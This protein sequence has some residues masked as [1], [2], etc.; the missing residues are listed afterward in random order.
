[1]AQG[2]LA[3]ATAGEEVVLASKYRAFQARLRELHRL[4]GKK[5]MENRV[6]EP[7]EWLIYNCSCYTAR[8][9][10]VFDRGI[11]LIPVSSPQSNGMAEAFAP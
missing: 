10:R 2:V 1:M 5:A 6:P 11:G 3:A 9:T 7:I 8:N 4:L